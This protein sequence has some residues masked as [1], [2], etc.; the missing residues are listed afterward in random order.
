MRR[1]GSAGDARGQVQSLGDLP[2]QL[3]VDD[4]HQAALLRH[5][6][7]QHEQ[8]EHMLR[9]DGDAVDRCPSRLQETEQVV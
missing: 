9:H 7:I 3:L 5:Q 4:L 8:V 1:E 6:H 2:P